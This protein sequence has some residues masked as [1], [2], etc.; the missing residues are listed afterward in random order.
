VND[1]STDKNTIHEIERCGNKYDFKLINQQNRGLA[2][3]R[4]NGISQVDTE[5]Y[6]CL[7]CDNKLNYPV[8]NEIIEQIKIDNRCDVY[9]TDVVFFGD[10]KKNVQVGE[11][12]ISKLLNRN[13]IDACAITRVSAWKA[14][15][16]YDPCMPHMGHEDWEFNVNLYFSG[17][18]HFY[19]P[20]PGFYY[21]V[22]NDS[23]SSDF[24]LSKISIS[25]IYIFEKH[26]TKISYEYT[27]LYQ[28]YL[29]EKIITLKK[30]KNYLIEKLTFLGRKKS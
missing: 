28:K 20:K 17:F 27:V 6:I 25:R 16:G 26:S 4:N 23:M 5:F 12:D 30:I 15:R 3:S 14:V 13:Y 18:K 8:I 9:Y 29:K 7:D 1:G 21:R 24:T 2:M 19:Y 11:F 22:R 10:E